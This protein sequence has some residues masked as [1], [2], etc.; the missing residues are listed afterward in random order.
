MR[1]PAHVRIARKFESAII[2]NL[3]RLI[4]RMFR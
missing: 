2:W 3:V 1:L 4:F